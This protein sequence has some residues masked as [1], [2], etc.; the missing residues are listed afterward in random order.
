MHTH[1]LNNAPLIAALLILVEVAPYPQVEHRLG[2]LKQIGHV[3]DLA[4]GGVRIDQLNGV[5]Q[6]TVIGAA[7]G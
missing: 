5:I 2:V 7:P 6:N 4:G 1:P 3:I